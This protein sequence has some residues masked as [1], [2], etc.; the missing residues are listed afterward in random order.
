V[1]PKRTVEDPP[2]ARIRVSSTTM[3]LLLEGA[4]DEIES[5]ATGRV[6]VIGIVWDER[7]S[8]EDV[9]RVSRSW[10]AALAE[11]TG[12]EMTRVRV[13]GDRRLEVEE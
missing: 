11:K 9:H 5:L 10:S 7:L 3:Q 4:A 1:N 12:V 8:R 2:P 6:T 13:Y